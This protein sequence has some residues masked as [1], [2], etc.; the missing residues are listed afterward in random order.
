ME[1]MPF[2]EAIRA[3][4]VALRAALDSI[5]HSTAGLV[6]EPWRASET[7][8]VLAM[9]ASTSTAHALVAALTDAGVRGVNLTPPDLASAPEG[10]EPGDHYV[11]VSE[12]GRSPEPLAVASRVS[13]GR[14]VGIT[15]YPGEAIAGAVDDLISLGE[16]DDS[17]VYS[18]GYTGTLLAYS[19]LCRLAGVES[20][21]IDEDTVPDLVATA[22]DTYLPLAA[23]VA[24]HLDAVAF[25]DVVGASYSYAAA[26]E[27]NLM[28]REA[29]AIASASF[30]TQQY[31]H[32][33]AEPA[34]PNHALLVLG[35]ERELKLAADL[36]A[37][38]TPVVLITGAAPERLTEARDA[39]VFVISLPQ[40]VPGLARAIVEIVA[41]QAIIEGIALN[42]AISIETF[43][44]SQPDTKIDEV[45]TNDSE[46]EA[47]GD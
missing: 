22:L 39:G 4:P 3:Q 11:V 45:G 33:P 19:H 36:A 32:G 47:L 7:V 13:P 17:A 18:I 46:K 31:L 9:G 28:F 5:R 35:D 41:V 42:R 23:D 15:N 24:V 26:T 14:R 1:Y 20:A 25:V 2:A 34:G 16:L 40:G 44:Y 27:A 12:S 6:I 8:A 29:L 10:F 30:Q 38:G 37:V 43:N 21:A